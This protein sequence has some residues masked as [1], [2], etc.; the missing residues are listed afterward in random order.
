MYAYETVAS[1]LECEGMI[2][3]NSVSLDAWKSWLRQGRASHVPFITDDG[4]IKLDKA[5]SYAFPRTS[6]A[7]DVSAG[8]DPNHS[9]PDFPAASEFG[10]Y[11]TLTETQID[12]LAEE[13]V[14]EIRKG[15]S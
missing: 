12:A 3:V 7:G 4:S 10:G 6:I 2:N 15:D 14:K 5:T 1:Q 13:I 11:R 9:N 8:S